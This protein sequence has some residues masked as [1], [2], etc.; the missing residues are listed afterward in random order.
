MKF[1]HVVNYNGTYYQ[2]GEEVPIEENAIDNSDNGEDTA[3]FPFVD[4]TAVSSPKKRSR[5]RREE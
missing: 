2:A 1:R 3:T 5:R 4:D